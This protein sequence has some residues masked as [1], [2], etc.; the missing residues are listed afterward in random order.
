MFW[1][2]NDHLQKADSNI[3]RELLLHKTSTS[4]NIERTSRSATSTDYTYIKKEKKTPPRTAI[5]PIF[6]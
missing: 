5:Y 6:H 3:L 1:S 4:T 2:I